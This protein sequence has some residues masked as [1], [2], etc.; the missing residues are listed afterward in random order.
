MYTPSKVIFSL[1]FSFVI[2]SWGIGSWCYEFD[3]KGIIKHLKQTDTIVAPKVIHQVLPD[4]PDELRKKGVEGKVKLQVMIDKQGNIQKIKVIQPLHP[5]LD[6]SAVQAVLQWKFEPALKKEKPIPVRT[7]LVIDFNPALRRILEEN[8]ETNRIFYPGILPQKDLQRILDQCAVYCKKLAN[9][10]LDFICEET[11]TDTHYNFY[12]E[13][14]KSGGSI[15]LQKETAEGD[16]IS[17]ISRRRDNWDSFKIEKNR[18]ICDYQMIKKGK[19]IKQ[20]RFILK[21]KDHKGEALK[22]PFEE[23][24]FSAL[25]P[26]FAPIRLFET[27]H[28]I[29]FYYKIIK[30]EKMDGAETY[31]I[32]VQPKPGGAGGVQYAKVWIDQ[33]NYQILKSEIKGFPIQGYENVFK[34]AILLKITP[35]FTMTTFFQVE[36]EEVL[37]PSRSTVLIEYPGLGLRRTNLKYDIEMTY[38]KYKFFTVETDHNI[39][40]KISN[41]FFFQNYD[42]RINLRKNIEFFLIK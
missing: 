12:T 20:R 3:A 6:F 26:L 42:Y 9:S 35:V 22:E 32:E 30:K 7:V 39:I 15:A 11:I 21:G 34:E 10:A 4:Y 27:E 13:E 36:K 29:M 38:K 33:T 40:K 5:F 37:F 8:T 16:V 18:Y 28:Q 14:N 41:Y 24:R 31:V 2:F 17:V 25:I 1:V 19:K 23:K